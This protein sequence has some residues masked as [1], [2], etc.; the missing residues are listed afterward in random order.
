VTSLT[1]SLAADDAIRL[2]FSTGRKEARATVDKAI[3]AAQAA[4]LAIPI[5][6]ETLQPDSKLQPPGATIVVAL[7]IDG[8]I[9]VG[10]L[11][12]SRAYLIS[13]NGGVLSGKL[14]TKDHSYINYLIDVE[15][16][17]LTNAL[18]G[19]GPDAHAI[20]KCLG[21]LEKGTELDPSFVSVPTQDAVCLL[22]CSDGLWNYA[23]ANQDEPPTKFIELAQPVLDDPL[24][25]ANTMIE[26]ANLSGGVD[27]ITACVLTF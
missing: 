17:T 25:I 13:R 19:A 20:T 18:A 11:G 10:W 8:M 2:A 4:V 6:P 5:S 24:K 27:N 12:D 23:H 26:F 16:K 1:A 14:I 21:L 15:G 7:V 9:T 22:L 3:R